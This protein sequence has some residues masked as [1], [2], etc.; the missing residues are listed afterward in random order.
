MQIESK[1]PKPDHINLSGNSFQDEN[2]PVQTTSSPNKSNRSL[3]IALGIAGIIIVIL[4]AV[5]FFLFTNNPNTSN[6]APTEVKTELKEALGKTVAETQSIVNEQGYT[7]TLVDYDTNKDWTDRI[8]KSST[9]S[10][11]YRVIKSD[12]GIKDFSEDKKTITYVVVVP[13]SES[14]EKWFTDSDFNNS[15]AS[16]QNNQIIRSLQEIYEPSN[17]NEEVS[18][19]PAT[20][21]QERAIARAKDYLKSSS[22]S[23]DEVINALTTEKFT[24]EDAKYAADHCDANWEEEATEAAREILDNPNYGISYTKLLQQLE[25]KKFTHNEAVK[26]IDNNHPNWTEQAEKAGRNRYYYSVLEG[27]ENVTSALVTEGFTY[28]EAL[29]GTEAAKKQYDERYGRY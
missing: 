15:G 9:M 28:E 17:K 26:G 2:I 5:I 4:C 24:K 11:Y 25:S 29:A 21:E 23:Y 13:L 3:K 7:M 16:E 1:N 10:K 22:K 19:E 12:E 6:S 8:L 20:A 27:E 14:W 18:N